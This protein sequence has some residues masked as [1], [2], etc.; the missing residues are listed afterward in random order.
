MKKLLALLGLLF[1]AGC[2]GAALGVLSKVAQGASYLGSLLDVAHGGSD[3]F[4]DRHPNPESEGRVARAELRA[5]KALAALEGAVAAGEAAD[6]GDRER[7]RSEAV[8]SYGELRGLLDELGVLAAR[9]P[10]GGAETEAP[11]PE[12][13]DLPL[14]DAVA[15]SF[16]P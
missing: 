3:A 1:L 11:K 6:A 16:S 12:P 2:N 4:F 9:S 8:A 13:L 10:Q 15:G 5:R 7:A 14:P